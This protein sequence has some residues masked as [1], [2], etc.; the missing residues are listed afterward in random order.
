MKFSRLAALCVGG[1]LVLTACGAEDSESGSKNQENRRLEEVSVAVLAPGSLQWLHAI[2]KDQGFY[3]EHGVQIEDVQVQN[4]GAL[5]QAVASASAD[6]GLALGD[7]VI[8]AVDEGADIRIVGALLQKPALR[9][10]AAEGIE[11]ISQLEGANVTAG[12]TEGGTFDL[13]LY[14]LQQ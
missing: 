5:V 2:S 7:N 4:S 13:L 9:L 3:E 8:K 12:A 6:T 1:S 10:F 11:D 14:I